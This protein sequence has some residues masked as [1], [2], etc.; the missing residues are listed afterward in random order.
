MKKKLLVFIIVFVTP[1]FASAQGYSS[2]CALDSFES[3]QKKSQLIIR[4]TKELIKPQ[5]DFSLALAQ[6]HFNVVKKGEHDGSTVDFATMEHQVSLSK[7]EEG[8]YELY[9]KIYYYDINEHILDVI[10]ETYY[11][12]VELLNNENEFLAA[13]RKVFSFNYDKVSV[14]IDK[15]GN[16]SLG[17]TF[18]E[19]LHGFI[20][21]LEFRLKN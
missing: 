12:G 10:S 13:Q 18:R 1:L 15:R 9:F 20:N 6:K 19:P 8:K 14:I 17:I 5:D 4:T 3:D 7:V 21:G 11:D 2:G 16:C